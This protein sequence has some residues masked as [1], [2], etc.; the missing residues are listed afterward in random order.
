MSFADQLLADVLA[1]GHRSPDRDE[2]GERMSR[3][4]PW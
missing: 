2:V 4:A 1:D 3:N